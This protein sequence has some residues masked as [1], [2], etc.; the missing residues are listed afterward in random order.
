[1][2]VVGPQLPPDHTM[3]HSPTPQRFAPARRDRVGAGFT[4]IELLVVIG[5][6]A[7]LMA[8]ILSA[9][10]RV[11]EAAKRT[12]CLNKIRQQGL[13]GLHYESVSGHLPPGAVQGPF[14][15]LGR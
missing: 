10:Q 4:L 8:L 6:D 7:V 9:V 12:E 14:A 1:M 15:P 3:S 5:I 2:R 13:A 11:R